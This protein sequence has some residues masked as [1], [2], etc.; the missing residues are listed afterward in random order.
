M[1]L[2]VFLGNPGDKY[3]QN[4]HNVAWLFADFL[5]AEWKID[6]GFSREKKLFA[7]TLVHDADGVKIL[8]LKPT[9]FMNRSGQAV[10]AALRFYKLEFTDILIVYDD[11]DIP[12]GKVRF[13]EKGSGGGHNGMQ[14]IID[15]LGSQDIA[16]LKIGVDNELRQELDIDTSTF[17]LS[18]FTKAEQELLAAEVFPAVFER[19]S[20]WITP[21]TED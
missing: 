14:N 16:R 13:R 5:R 15:L 17:V 10:V 19:L 4:R 11:K 21:D 20:Q 7:H 3:A 6:S 18:D 1:K 9:T 8:M 12:L 2:V